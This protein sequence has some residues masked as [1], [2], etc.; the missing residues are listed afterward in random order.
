MYNGYP[1]AQYNFEMLNLHSLMVVKS[2][3]IIDLNRFT[4]Q[5]PQ[6][7]KFSKLIKTTHPKI[8]LMIYQ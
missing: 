3:I 5:R 6:M 1:L 7:K 8:V 4:H 2:N